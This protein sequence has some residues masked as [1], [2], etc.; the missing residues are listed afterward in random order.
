MSARHWRLLF[1]GVL[2]WP[3]AG[4]VRAQEDADVVA[5]MQKSHRTIPSSVSDPQQAQLILEQHLRRARDRADLQKLLEN[6]DLKKLA[7]D[8]LHDP[9]RFGVKDEQIERLKERFQ[10]GSGQVKPDLGDPDLRQLL[11][12]VL[13]KRGSG[14]GAA[15][16]PQQQEAFKRLVE[17]FPGGDQQHPGPGGVPQLPNG[18]PGPAGPSPTEVPPPAAPGGDAKEGPPPGGP[19]GAPSAPPPPPDAAADR[20]ARLTQELLKVAENLQKMDP[21]LKN[22]PALK[23]FMRQLSHYTGSSGKS[24]L[25]LPVSAS[26]GHLGERLPRLGEYLHLE[27][28]RPDPERW[29]QARSLLPTPPRLPALKQRPS[30]P[31]VG[32]MPRATAATAAS[33]GQ[34]LLWVLLV[35]GFGVALWRLFAWQKDRVVRA[36]QAGWRLGPWPVQPA[37]V[38]TRA[39]L[40]R[41]FDYLALLCLGPAARA[42]NHLEIAARLGEDARS[43]PRRDAAS[44]LALLYEQARY[45]PPEDPLPDADLA[46]ARRHL[47]LL[48]GVPC[49]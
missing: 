35:V 3:A 15:I 12:D 13:E 46:A 49:A 38:A 11:G 45:A 30:L 21:A 16:T 10:D 4:R 39:D 37:A 25:K 23:N 6:P 5:R 44:R 24:A 27:R 26:V 19:G 31:A 47:C 7:E 18:T 17:S 34:M 14:P 48:A 2:L 32:S 41:A 22:S 42:W 28:W 8:V 36:R 9:K 33:G 29:Q 1:L 20:Q 40:V 43:A